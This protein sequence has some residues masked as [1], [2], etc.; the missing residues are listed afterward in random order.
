MGMIDK[1][2]SPEELFKLANTDGDEF[3]SLEEF[4]NVSKHMRLHIS[5][6]NLEKI[7]ATVDKKRT[8]KLN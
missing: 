5:N 6:E 8:R 7:F 2:N 4:K 3:I 1:K